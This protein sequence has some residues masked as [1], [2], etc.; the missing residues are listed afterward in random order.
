MAFFWRQDYMRSAALTVSLGARTAMTDLINHLIIVAG[1]SALDDLGATPQALATDN[2]WLL[3]DRERGRKVPSDILNHIRLGVALF[4]GDPSSVLI[5]SGGA[6]RTGQ[7]WNSAQT[8]AASYDAVA[9]K[10]WRGIDPARMLQD[11][12]SYNSG[13][14]VL[15]SLNRFWQFTGN[16]P[17]QLT[18]V[19]RDFKQERF[20]IYVEAIEGEINKQFQFTFVGVRDADPAYAKDSRAFE[21][22]KQLPEL[23]KN[24]MLDF[25]VLKGS[26]TPG[27]QDIEKEGKCPDLKKLI[28]MSIE[29][30]K[31]GNPGD[32]R[33][34]R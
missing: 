1:N 19:S 22:D 15:F 30:A 3:K 16:L 23:R 29:A 27:P 21:F 10:L 9:R 12:Y 32:A 6:T 33:E 28:N 24:P 7:P 31:K 14:N 18:V 5:F 34:P 13:H 2:A 25:E 8:E 20:R 26:R 4:E 11:I 17:E